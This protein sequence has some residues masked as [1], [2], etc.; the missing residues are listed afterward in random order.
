MKILHL[1]NSLGGGGKERRMIQLIK[2][3]T[4]VGYTNQKIITFSSRN[5]YAGQLIALGVEVIVLNHKER[6]KIVR[7]L[8]RAILYY[9]PT[10]I[11][12]W[13]NMSL[14]M[15]I[16]P[17]FK[18]ILKF[19]YLAGFIADANKVPLFSLNKLAM[20]FSFRYADAIVSNSRAGLI[21]KNAPSKKSQ[22]I[23]NGFDFNRLNN[24]ATF[25]TDIKVYTPYI[26]SMFASFCPHKDYDMFLTVAKSFRN[27]R[28]DITFLAIGQGEL[29][30]FYI[31]RAQK[32]N[33]TNIIFL[34]FRKDV[35]A[36]LKISDICLLF[37]DNKF[38]A[39][40]V[41]NAIMEAMAAGKPV[42]ATAGGGTTEIIDN[43]KN[44]YII[45]PK[46][47][48]SAVSIIN[49]LLNSKQL[50]KNI[51]YAAVAKIKSC[52][53]LECMTSKYIELYKLIIK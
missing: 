47:I 22:V 39:E 12:S 24:T 45:K 40:G 23:Y 43:K 17:F 50:R 42:I 5:D 34:G 19:R 1:I 35:E 26:I 2:G 36:I 46:D 32:E 48:P 31:H 11:H 18:P 6:L 3:L 28:N 27:S 33:I 37:T 16:L 8:F 20:F 51:G 38:H 52:F 41:S 9:K 7:D 44:G 25:Q 21:A 53:L 49:E 30:D 15:L 29:L 13:C 10:I 14:I 4:D